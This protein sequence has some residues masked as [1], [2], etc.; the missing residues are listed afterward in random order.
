MAEILSPEP[1][2]VEVIK[3][4]PAADPEVEELPEIGVLIGYGSGPS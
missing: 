3:A 1:M 2:P 4:F